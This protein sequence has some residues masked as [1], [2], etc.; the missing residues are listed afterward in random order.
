MDEH[1]CFKRRKRSYSNESL[2][3]Y[4]DTDSDEIFFDPKKR[5]N[6]I[7]FK[8]INIQETNN[9]KDDNDLVDLLNNI[10]KLNIDSNK[11]LFTKIIKK[12]S[13]LEKK[14][15]TILMVNVKI[16]TL[17]KDID[18]ILVEKDYVIENLKYEIND[19]KDQL[20]ESKYNIDS[21]TQKGINSYYS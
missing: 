5:M 3:E 1:I 2:L 14:V 17:K 19:L 7:D 8:G 15:E 11:D 13:D 12:I 18:K 16:D 21:I 4:S 20:K 6:A 9:N 10:N